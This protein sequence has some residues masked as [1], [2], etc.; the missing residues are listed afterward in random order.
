MTAT[1]LTDA[2]GHAMSAMPA[3]MAMTPATMRPVSPP[4]PMKN[5]RMPAKRRKRPAKIATRCT[6]PQMLARTRMPKTTATMPTASTGPRPRSRPGGRRRRPPSRSPLPDAAGQ[7]RSRTRSCASP[8]LVW[9]PLPSAA[10]SYSPST[11][12]IRRLGGRRR[13]RCRRPAARGQVQSSVGDRHDHLV[14]DEHVLEVGVA[15][16]LAARGDGSR[17]GRA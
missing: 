7:G 8:A 11:L 9:P 6:L 2:S 10:K 13:T 3:T 4:P 1:V 15:V 5:C 16:V 17:R 14:V 12:M